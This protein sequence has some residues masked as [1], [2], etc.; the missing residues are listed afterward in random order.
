M[1]SWLGGTGVTVLAV[2]TLPMLG[3]D[4]TQLLRAE[5]PGMDRESKMAPRISQAAKELWF[6]Y[7]LTT[8][9]A[10]VSLC[11]AGMSWF[12][13]LYRTMLAVA[14]GG[15]SAHDDNIT[16]LNSISIRWVPILFTVFGTI[17]F[18]GYFAAFANR[19]LKAY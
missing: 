5:I 14:L 7:T 17:N 10:F 18:V 2:A 9:V 1:L 19:L 4:G 6:S 15:F 8:T 3:V 13:T 11:L 12:D 16:Y